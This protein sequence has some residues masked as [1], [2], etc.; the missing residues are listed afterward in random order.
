[1]IICETHDALNAHIAEAKAAGKRV[2]FVPTMGAL[3]EGHLSLVRA[4]KKACDFVVASI[5][6]NPPQFAPDEDFE[7]YPR[8]TDRDVSLLNGAGVDVVYLP[9][10]DEVYPNGVTVTVNAGKAAAGL[11]TD[12]RPH[13]FDG[14]CSV[15][16]RLFELVEPDAAVFGEKDY[17]QLMVIRE[18]VEAH[19]MGVEIIGAPIIRDEHGLA[20]SSRNAYLSDEELGIARTLNVIIQESSLQG[21]SLQSSVQELDHM[22]K[23]CDDVKEKLLA[24]G[25]DK[26]DYIEERWGR[27]LAAAWIGKTRLIDNFEV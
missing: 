4:A 3:H 13:F 11:E 7:D 1:M 24:A 9:Q 12:F 21:L 14:V 18:M 10:V 27:I 8:D 26:V 20:L 23:P 22:D 5:F 16:H 17:Q 15:V 6:V 19:G 2:G 25:F